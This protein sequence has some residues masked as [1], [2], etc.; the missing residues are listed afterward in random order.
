MRWLL[1]T[2]LKPVTE[3]FATVLAARNDVNVLLSGLRQPSGPA[4][5]KPG[6]CPVVVRLFVDGFCVFADALANANAA[7]PALSPTI[8]SR[9]TT[10]RVVT[11]LRG[12]G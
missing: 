10:V 5:L 6:H 2:M 7:A 11:V 12:A 8:S 4:P 3:T 9:S 1:S